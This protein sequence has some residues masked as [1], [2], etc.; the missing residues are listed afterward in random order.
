MV[1]PSFHSD[2]SYRLTPPAAS[3]G[4]IFFPFSLNN[5]RAAKEILWTAS[6]GGPAAPKNATAVKRA[7]NCHVCVCQVFWPLVNACRVILM[8]ATSPLLPFSV[9]FRLSIS[10]NFF[11]PPQLVPHPHALVRRSGGIFFQ[12]VGCSLAASPGTSSFFFR[13]PAAE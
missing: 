13:P 9:D 5:R 7:V 12:F 11:E 10:R 3:G 4:S 8:A 1:F 2:S 6:T